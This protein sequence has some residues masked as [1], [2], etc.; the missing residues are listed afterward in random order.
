MEGAGGAE[1]SPRERRE[2]RSGGVRLR[3]YSQLKLE[4]LGVR[5]SSRMERVVGMR[6][7]GEPFG[8]SDPIR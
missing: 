2:R 7:P 6:V 8:E 3:I 1:E 5:K 4:L